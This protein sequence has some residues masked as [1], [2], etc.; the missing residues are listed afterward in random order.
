MYQ[1]SKTPC[2]GKIFNYW[3]GTQLA[4]NGSTG[5]ACYLQI[6]KVLLF[7]SEALYSLNSLGRW[8]HLTTVQITHHQH[9][10]ASYGLTLRALNEGALERLSI[11]TVKH[12]NHNALIK[13]AS[14]LR[15][16]IYWLV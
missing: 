6:V 16:N 10:V 14:A 15:V 12:M 11:S 1:N 8:R 2:Y 7:K 4:A 9:S 5:S 3:Q 13:G